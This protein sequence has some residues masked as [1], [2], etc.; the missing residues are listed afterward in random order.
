MYNNTWV[1]C[2]SK[3]NIEKHLSSKFQFFLYIFSYKSIVKY[4]ND[5]N[6]VYVMVAKI[7][8][9]FQDNFELSDNITP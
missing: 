2:V 6:L 5:H 4:F 3:Q 9:N 1:F 8:K 7:I